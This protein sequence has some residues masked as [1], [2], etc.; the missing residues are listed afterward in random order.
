MLNSFMQKKINFIEVGLT[1]IFKNKIWSYWTYYIF[2]K[3]RC[4]CTPL[5][6]AAGACGGNTLLSQSSF[7]EKCIKITVLNAWKQLMAGATSR[8]RR[9]GLSYYVQ[10]G[11]VYCISISRAKSD[12]RPFSLSTA[13]AYLY[14]LPNDKMSSFALHKNNQKCHHQM[15]FSSSKYTAS[16]QTHS[17]SLLC[18]PDSLAGLQGRGRQRREGTGRKEKGGR[19]GKART[20]EGKRP[21]LCKSL[22]SRVFWARKSQEVTFLVIFMQSKWRSMITMAEGKFQPPQLP[23]FSSIFLKLKTKK[24]LG[25][26]LQAKFGKDRLTGGVYANT[27]ILAVHSGLRYPIYFFFYSSLSILVAP[28]VL[29]YCDQWGLKTRVPG[30]ESDFGGRLNNEK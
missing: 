22:G 3:S 27:L 18:S 20:G 26:E 9:Q 25:H 24:H 6:L 5:H 10:G 13:L 30:Q 4:K 29:L 16:P 19:R 21:P 14:H 15:R 7:K 8:V 11:R 17:G 2:E 1:V 12:M 28:R 23:H